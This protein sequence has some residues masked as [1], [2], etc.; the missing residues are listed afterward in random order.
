MN[1]VEAAKPLESPIKIVEVFDKFRGE[2]S[3]GNPQPIHNTAERI[4]EFD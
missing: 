1:G 3:S 2:L 4:G